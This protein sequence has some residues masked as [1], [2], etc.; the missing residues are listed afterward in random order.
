[1]TTT[2]DRSGF[3]ALAG[4][5]NVG[6]STLANVLAGAHVAAV[7]PRPQTTRRRV[8][9][10][11]HGDGWQAVLL[12]MPGFQ[13]P[14]D[15]LTKRMQTTVDQ[16]V[17]DCDVVL[18]VLNAAEAIGAGDRFIAERLRSAGRP[19]ILV[20]NKVD[21]LAPDAIARAIDAAT[22]LLDFSSLHPVS[23]LT[24]DGLPELRKA[25]A[26]ALP[27][28][29]A[30]FPPGVTT[31]Q[32]DAELAAEIIREAAL[33]RVRDEVPHAVAVHVEAI[34]PARQGRVVRAVIFVETASQKGILVG[35]GGAMIRAI[36]QA[37]R[38]TLTTMWGEPA[39]TD[40]VVKVRPKWRRDETMLDRLGL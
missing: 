18:F 8:T 27:E 22:G 12:D 38:R 4:R 33:Q 25:L 1:V 3:V 7:S 15:G 2:T 34:D 21:Q 11:A 24:G 13:R 19:V 28:G 20:L 10:V 17:G 30:Y 35:Q 16:T 29:P 5:P 37:S 40:L 32:T 36:G 23:A 26:S 39:H 9:A 14:A 6:K 31:D